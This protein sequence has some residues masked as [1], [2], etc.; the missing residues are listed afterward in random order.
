MKK[1]LSGLVLMLLANVVS[2]QVC[3]Y[4][5][6]GGP[7]LIDS[8]DFSGGQGSNFYYKVDTTLTSN[9]WQVGAVGKNGF[10]ANTFGSQAMQTDTANAY[11]TSNVSIFYVWTDSAAQLGPDSVFSIHFWH[12][13]DVD[14]VGD[15]CLVQISLDSGKTWLHYADVMQLPHLDYDYQAPNAIMPYNS[16]KFLWTGKSNGWQQVK[17]CFNYFL[18]KPTRNINWPIGYRFLFKSDTIQNNKPGW[19]IDKIR[20]RTP[21]AFGAVRDYQNNTLPIYPNPG[22]GGKFY[23]DFPSTYITGQFY[24][25][26]FLGQHVKTIPLTEYI[27]LSALPSGVYSYK[28]VFENTQQWY[29]GKIEIR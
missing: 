20:F 9:L 3:D 26:N 28:A 5:G 10:P 11:D 15:S 25:F 1:L 18:L 17:I 4:I 13:Y 29:S 21:A 12:Y 22:I 2:A 19:V 14:S 8:S 7:Y 27:D 24:V 6:L 16:G 23:I